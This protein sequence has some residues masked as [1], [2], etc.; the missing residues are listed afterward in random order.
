MSGPAQIRVAA[1]WLYIVAATTLLNSLILQLLN[2]FVDL[3]AGLWLTQANDAVWMGLRSVEPQGAP[4]VFEILSA[5]I[6]DA[7][8]VLIVV[9]FAVKI[10]RGSRRVAGISFFVY[11]ADTAVFAF[12]LEDSVRS[13]VATIF[14]GWQLLTFV[15]HVVG[16]VI[17]FRAWR[18]LRRSHQP[19]RIESTS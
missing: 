4:P 11:L 17:I 5:L 10:S 7:L 16:T 19:A 18:V 9:T 1:L 8:V 2:H 14:L 3:F 15:A 13:H 6:V 12:F